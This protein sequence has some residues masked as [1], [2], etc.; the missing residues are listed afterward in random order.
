MNC[1]K[2]GKETENQ[3]GFCQ[4]CLES[5][6]GYPVKPGTA[7][8]LPARQEAAVPKKPGYKKKVLT[9]EEQV[10]HLQRTVRRLAALAVLL[11]VLLATMGAMLVQTM[12]DKD[13]LQ[14]G[15]NYTINLTGN[16]NP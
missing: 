3:Q 8:H 5:M 9:T 15:R 10:L 11:A 14:L 12:M 7:V 13:E 2:C 1:L 4:R 16:Q 6:E